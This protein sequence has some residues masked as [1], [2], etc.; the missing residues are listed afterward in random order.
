M[1]KGCLGRFCNQRVKLNYP[2]L[3]FQYILFAP[4][5]MQNKYCNGIKRWIT[6]ETDIK[7]EDGKSLK[8]SSG[9][10]IVSEQRIE[11]K[12]WLKNNVTE[13]IFNGI[14]FRDNRVFVINIYLF[15]PQKD[16]EPQYLEI[17][18]IFKQLLNSYSIYHLCLIVQAAVGNF[19][20]D[21]SLTEKITIHLK[22]DKP[23][24]LPRLRYA[25]T[26]HHNRH[27]KFISHG[28]KVRDNRI[29]NNIIYKAISRI[30]NL[31]DFINN[32][33]QRPSVLTDYTSKPRLYNSKHKV[34]PSDGVSS[35]EG[36][37]PRRRFNVFTP[38][39]KRTHNVCNTGDKA[40]KS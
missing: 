40:S 20:K 18:Q 29:W 11:N 32:G 19:Y 6:T 16:Y 30:E 7:D 13:C 9:K 12:E 4:L 24:R 1:P 37:K 25:I 33:E 22:Y 34:K 38:G 5:E 14:L 8:T 3:L 17:T 26:K 15:D 2:K 23:Y 31:S 36:R 28:S 21:S 35:K 10:F 27:V 39:D